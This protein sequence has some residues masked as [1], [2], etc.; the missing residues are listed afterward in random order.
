MGKWC[1]KISTDTQWCGANI[2]KFN[3]YQNSSTCNLHCCPPT[4]KSFFWNGLLWCLP[5]FPANIIPIVRDGATTLF[6]Y[7]KWEDNWAPKDLWPEHFKA[8]HSHDGTLKDLHLLVRAEWFTAD[9]N[10]GEIIS[11]LTS[12]QGPS[13]AKCWSL[14]PNGCVSVKSFY[15]F[16][17]NKELWGGGFL[18]ATTNLIWKSICPKKVNFS[19]GWCANT[20]S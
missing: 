4:W 11:W 5:A 20:T 6:W 9:Q 16:L 8:L 17:R 10:F 15:G 1:W 12:L 19:T 14:T 7:D 2:I 18:C 13:D 3:Y